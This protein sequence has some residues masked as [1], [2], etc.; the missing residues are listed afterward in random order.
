VT[1]FEIPKMRVACDK[2]VANFNK[3]LAAH[4]GDMIPLRIDEMA[5]GF[6]NRYSMELFDMEAIDAGWLAPYAEAEEEA[7]KF[8]EAMDTVNTEPLDANYTVSYKWRK[9]AD[10]DYRVEMA[11]VVD[12]YNPLFAHA[13]W[14]AAPQLAYWAP[15]KMLGLLH[16]SF[17]LPDL[18]TY[19]SIC[20]TLSR[21]GLQLV[22]SCSSSYG[23]FAYF[24]FP[25]EYL[26]ENPSAPRPYLKPRVNLR[27][28]TSYAKKLL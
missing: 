25:E 11:R 2:A 23:K 27:D 26:R 18:E 13:R 10:S 12:G 8:N 15:V 22:Q 1:D 21:R 7:G 3:V 17:K 6:D 16:A 14:K 9:A 20:Y 5:I 19:E 24:K 28:G 4:L